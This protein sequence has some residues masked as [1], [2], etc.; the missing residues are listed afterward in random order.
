MRSSISFGGKTVEMK[1]PKCGGDDIKLDGLN[2]TPAGM[3]VSRITC[4]S[5]GHVEQPQDVKSNWVAGGNRI[6]SK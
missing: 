6:T 3:S 2:V 4:L 1:C 5:C